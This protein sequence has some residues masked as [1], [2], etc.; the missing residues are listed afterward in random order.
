MRRSSLL[1]LCLAL[2]LPA[3]LAA[4]RPQTREGFWISFGLG[5]GPSWLSCDVCT[6]DFG[7]GASGHLA[8]GGTITPQLVIGG[9]MLG[10]FP[11]DLADEGYDEDTDGFG[12]ALFTMHYYPRAEGGLFLLG[13]V[14]F[15]QIDVQQDQLEAN[16]Y[17]GQAG[18]GYDLRAARNF[19]ITPTL[20]LVQSFGTETKRA[21]VE[22]DET[23]NFGMLQLGISVTWH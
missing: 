3:A 13:G 23:M 2:A 4:Q 15:G 7:G 20:A 21:G 17:V 6:D 18:I 9:D 12:T 19:S 8:L 11:W 16:G 14:G 1:T 10:W 22:Q 5:G